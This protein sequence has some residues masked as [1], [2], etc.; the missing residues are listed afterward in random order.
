MY[1]NITLKT[2]PLIALYKNRRRRRRR[3]I[4][5]K[6]GHSIGTI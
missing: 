3:R 1:I 5:K 2:I 6:A 4:S